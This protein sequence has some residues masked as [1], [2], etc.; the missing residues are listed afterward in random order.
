MGST[1]ATAEASNYVATTENDYQQR[2]ENIN[3]MANVTDHD[4]GMK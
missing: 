3:I 4:E 2:E 1:N